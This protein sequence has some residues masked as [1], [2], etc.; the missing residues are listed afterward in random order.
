LLWGNCENR[1][2][3]KAAA[4]LH[5]AVF[6]TVFVAKI[7]SRIAKALRKFSQFPHSGKFTKNGAEWGFQTRPNFCNRI[8]AADLRGL[9]RI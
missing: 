5:R 1:D 4:H 3:K 7:M 8:L 6:A 9:S 2:R